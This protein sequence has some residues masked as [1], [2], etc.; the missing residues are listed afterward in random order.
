MVN[1]KGVKRFWRE[2]VLTAHTV[3]GGYLSIVLDRTGYFVHRLVAKA[4]VPP[5]KGKTFVNHKDGDKL[6]NVADNLEWV[7]HAENVKHV[8]A[9]GKHRGVGETHLWAKLK[10]SDVVLIKSLLADHDDK[11][12]GKRFGVHHTTIKAIRTGRNWKQVK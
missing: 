7:T 11:E 4:F 6:N 10:R 1:E 9:I 5:V 3:R 8:F 12:L 2:R